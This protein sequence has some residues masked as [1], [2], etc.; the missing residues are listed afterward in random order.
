MINI[1]IMLIFQSSFD[2]AEVGDS[3]L[4]QEHGR[5]DWHLCSGSVLNVRMS[6]DGWFIREILYKMDDL[7]VALF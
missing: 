6:H 4:C 1:N 2:L 7:G 5:V 3:D